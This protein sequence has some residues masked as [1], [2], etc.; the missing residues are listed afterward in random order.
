MTA[1]YTAVEYIVTP[2]SGS[3]LSGVTE[4]F[5]WD[6]SDATIDEW[7]LL[8]GSTI[9]SFNYAYSAGTGDSNSTQVNNLPIDGSTIYIRLWLKVSGTWK[10]IDLFYTAV[11]S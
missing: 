1:S 9:G 2:V 6:T 3:T 10:Y 5:S 4:T 7:A 11:D 8:A